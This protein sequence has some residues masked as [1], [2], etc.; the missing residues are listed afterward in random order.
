M[1]GKDESGT[2]AFNQKYDKFHENK[3]KAHTK[4]LLNMVRRK[5][6]GRIT[7]WHIIVIISTDIQNVPAKVWTDSFVALSLHPQRRFS[8]YDRKK[9]ILQDVKTGGTA[10][11]WNH[12]SS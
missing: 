12:E 11:F 10:Y 9:N 7:Q 6:H 4:Q 5:V 1:V 3:D 8:F 2:S